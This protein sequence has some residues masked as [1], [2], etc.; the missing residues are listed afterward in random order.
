MLFRNVLIERGVANA[1]ELDVLEQE[2]AQEVEEAVRFAEES[3]YPEPEVAF[4]DLYTD[5]Y[6]IEVIS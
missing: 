4:S 5:P 3:P 6:P 1:E 2:V